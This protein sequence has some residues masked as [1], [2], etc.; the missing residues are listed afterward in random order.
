MASGFDRFAFWVAIFLM[1]A[2]YTLPGLGQLGA[3][4]L[5]HRS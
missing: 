2:G 1:F 5:L 4:Y 3:L